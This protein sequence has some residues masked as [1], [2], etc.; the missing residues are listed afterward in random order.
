MSVTVAP[1]KV[2]RSALWRQARSACTAA[3]SAATELACWTIGFSFGLAGFDPPGVS[4][5][6]N[7]IREITRLTTSE[8]IPRP[9]VIFWSSAARPE[10][11]IIDKPD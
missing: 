6:E 10:V 5:D 8:T 3:A 4:C 2:P 11:L 9:R 7:S 1:T